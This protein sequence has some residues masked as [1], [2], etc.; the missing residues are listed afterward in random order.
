M[1]MFSYAVREQSCSWIQWQGTNSNWCWYVI[2]LNTKERHG[3]FLFVFNTGLL[4]WIPLHWRLNIWQSCVQDQSSVSTKG[5]IGNPSG[6]TF[7]R[8]GL[9]LLDWVEVVKNHARLSLVSLPSLYSHK[10]LKCL[11]LWPYH[12]LSNFRAVVTFFMPTGYL[13]G[14]MILCWEL[15][16]YK[17][18]FPTCCDPSTSSM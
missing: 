10:G 9:L 2:W 12:S 6:S 1:K 16:T 14:Q 11:T 3:V 4:L 15:P 7:L 5:W 17:T 13:L 18:V 8:E